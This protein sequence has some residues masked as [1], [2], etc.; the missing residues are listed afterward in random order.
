LPTILIA[1]PKELQPRLQTTVFWREDM[2]RTLAAPAEVF[3]VARTLSP[4]LI[5]LSDDGDAARV[6]DVLEQLR[7]EPVTHDAIVIL[8]TSA[9]DPQSAWDRSGASIV[10]PTT[11]SDAGEQAPWHLK[12][13][14]LLNLRQRRETR[15]LADLPARA[16]FAVPGGGPKT[17]AAMALNISSRGMLLETPE[18]LPRGTRAELSFKLGSTDVAVVG[19]IVRTAETADG[20]KLA[21]VHFVVVRKEARL[22][23]RDYLRAQRP[24]DDLPSAD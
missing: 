20:H 24:G 5:V 12:L 9:D 7:R 17:V 1:I 2:R 19:E 18:L 13:E 16:T 23:I 21:G 4:D 6:R 14:E 11:F 3:A 10:L 8:L 22:G 15:V